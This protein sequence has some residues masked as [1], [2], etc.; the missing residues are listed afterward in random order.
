MKKLCI[1]F[2]AFILM[3][4][5]LSATE[6]T[7]I[8]IANSGGQ[9]FLKLTFKEG[10]FPM[11]FQKLD[12]DQLTISFLETQSNLPLGK[13]PVLEKG[14]VSELTLKKII[15]PSGKNFMGITLKL[16]SLAGEEYEISP[17]GKNALR[18]ILEKK[19]TGK[20]N[21]S[22]VHY[23]EEK[24]QEQVRQEKIA[25]QEKAKADEKA[26]LE[27]KAKAKADAQANAEAEKKAKQEAKVKA[28]AEAKQ[29]ME[30]AK[31]AKLAAQ[32]KA[33][34][35][36]KTQADEK[37]R[38]LAEAKAKTEADKKAAL[39]AKAKAKADAQAN[40]EAE[41][42]A[43]QEAKVKALAEAKQKTEEAKLAKLAAQEK[44]KA[45]AK[46]QA[47]EKTRLLAEAKAKAEAEAKANAPAKLLEVKWL[48][49]NTHQNLLF[50][51]EGTVKNFSLQNG[52]DSLILKAKLNR[53][54]N[55]LTQNKY[56][57]PENDLIKQIRFKNE[58]G[59]LIAEIQLQHKIIA[60]LVSSEGLLAITFDEKP[61]A[62]FQW[63]SQMPKT[64]LNG[65]N[66]KPKDED[67]IVSAHAQGEN[68]DKSSEQK[69]LTS[70]RIFSLVKGTKILVSIKDSTALKMG[71][72]AKDSLI[73]KIPMGSRVR[74]LAR[75]GQWLH[76]AHENDSG[77]VK[78]S[79]FVYEDELTS[80]Q[81][82]QIEKFL[83]AAEAKRNVKVAPSE[84][85]VAAKVKAD[86]VDV[87]NAVPA[88]VEI[89][90]K[91]AKS[92]V[93]KKP[94]EIKIMPANSE[95]MIAKI[96]QE[97]KALEQDKIKVQQE[98]TVTYNSYG[99]RDPFIPVQEG[100]A[101]NGIDIDQ[102]KVVGIVYKNKEPIAVLEHL[103]EAGISYTVKEG[104]PV[105]NGKVSHISGDAVTFEITEYSISRSYTLKLVSSQ[106]RTKK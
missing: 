59:N 33:K 87:K 42:K 66:G 8:S 35:D 54:Q 1:L 5:V 70:S 96:E 48:A 23:L 14:P 80:K 76:V 19:S 30:E 10:E 29:K 82:A 53:T 83:L 43:K 20:F 17:Q 15:S 60:K 98:N 89:A 56:V 71:E 72:G 41:K 4:T 24:K 81:S 93:E 28:L 49:S 61:N 51:F 37:M 103:K 18:L 11:Y 57:L 25:A 79:D 69:P 64:F 50:R 75:Q 7:D 77:Y 47:D 106:E 44:A 9:T 86:S 63:S 74:K 22:V 13:Y 68:L 32:E 95:V 34:A 31:L 16:V 58:K 84:T 3:H 36:A 52:N 88:K 65:A 2:L 45:D 27:V 21:W 67:A 105:H 92:I 6:I 12:A 46:T 26:A 102:M 39:E 99:R 55:A 85:T 94:P 91:N 78:L 90:V 104:D 101:E 40:A 38:L 62:P 73:K 97:K 100:R